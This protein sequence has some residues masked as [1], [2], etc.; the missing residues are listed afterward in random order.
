MWDN[1]DHD[2]PKWPVTYCSSPSLQL[3]C[4]ER[5]KSHRGRKPLEV[6]SQALGVLVL[7]GLQESVVGNLPHPHPT[8]KECRE[9]CST[10]ELELQCSS[11]LVRRRCD[12]EWGGP[13]PWGPDGTRP[14]L[15]QCSSIL[16]PSNPPFLWL[17]TPLVSFGGI[18][19]QV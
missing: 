15:V 10:E 13:L 5:H 16:L 14:G 19:F 2:G 9:H 12:H 4:L 8:T 1:M 17:S 18:L 7:V 6:Q 3:P 11:V